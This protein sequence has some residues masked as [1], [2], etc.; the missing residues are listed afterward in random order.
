MVTVTVITCRI[1]SCCLE[2]DLDAG[3]GAKNPRSLESVQDGE[4]WLTASMAWDR[5]FKPIDSDVKVSLQ[6]AI[7]V[8]VP[9][10]VTCWRLGVTSGEGFSFFSYPQTFQSQLLVKQ[11]KLLNQNEV[12]PLFRFRHPASFPSPL[13][14]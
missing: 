2:H 9:L 11:A 6:C 4:A 8:R 14:G 7:Q 5:L 3:A 12:D 10:T 1:Q 13:E